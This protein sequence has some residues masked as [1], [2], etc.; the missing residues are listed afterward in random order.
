MPVIDLVGALVA[1]EHDLVGIDDDDI[2]AA[3]HMRREARLVLAS[4]PRGDQGRK[5]AHDEAF[6]IDEDPGLLDVLGRR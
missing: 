6:G 4:E 3:I 5:P 2:V 1:G